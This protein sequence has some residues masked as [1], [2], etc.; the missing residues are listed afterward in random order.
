MFLK[1]R[2]KEFFLG[3]RHDQPIPVSEEN[4]SSVLAF[5]DL[6]QKS[7]GD[8]P[9][10][11]GYVVSTRWKEIMRHGSQLIEKLDY[12]GDIA[13]VGMR[14]FFGVGLV[15]VKDFDEL[16]NHRL[17]HDEWHP[18]LRGIGESPLVAPPAVLT[19]KG[20]TYSHQ[21]SQF[22][23]FYHE[24]VAGIGNAELNT[25]IEIGSGSGCFVRVLK[26]AGRGKRFILVDLPESLIFA[27]AF[28]RMHFPEAKMHI[29]KSADDVTP[30][31]ET[32][33]DFLFCPAQ[34]LHRLRPQSVDLLV[35]TYSLG[36][37][38]QGCID[39]IMNC[40]HTTLRPRFFWSYNAIFFNKNAHFAESSNTG[41]GSEVV[42]KLEAKWWPL[43]FHVF[44]DLDNG[45]WRQYVST[46]LQWTDKPAT[47][48]AS[49]LTAAAGSEARGS[50]K[51]LG[52]MYLA[53][54]WTGDR[55]TIG[56]FL[57]G[58]KSRHVADH[59]NEGP[60]YDFEKVGEVRFLRR[61]AEA[62]LPGLQH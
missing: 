55:R 9:Y 45:N 16:L 2:L 4:R 18:E 19:H 39:H 15:P 43:T 17:Q 13:V 57:E 41:E 34:F 52:Y 29:V 50:D 60:S 59:L 31:M 32:E 37:M 61:R 58:L 3:R 44:K 36:E 27:F 5:R 38:Q 22:F 56:E 51:W 48:L 11:A 53:S 35:N 33:F 46:V 30:G 1:Q 26:L 20:I 47:Q 42:L 14:E 10:P 49:D 62:I 28:L 54:L 24:L 21:L 6:V 12:P 7:L 23:S 8:E 40:I 25:V